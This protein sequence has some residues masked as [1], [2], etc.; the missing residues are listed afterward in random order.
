LDALA[1]AVS[2]LSQLALRDD[3]GVGEAEVNPLLIGRE[4]EGVTAVDALVYRV[5]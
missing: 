2:A 3:L 4:G 5:A 1:R